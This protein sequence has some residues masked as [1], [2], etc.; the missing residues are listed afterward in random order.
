MSENTKVINFTEEEQTKMAE[1]YTTFSELYQKI[2]DI[3]IRIL[4]LT[5]DLENA[6]NYR[7]SLEAAYYQLNETSKEVT[8]E[9]EKKYGPGT[10]YADKN[11]YIVSDVTK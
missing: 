8:G 9:I 5:K 11:E 7:T 10:Y 3:N 6:T 4:D 1:M 2:G